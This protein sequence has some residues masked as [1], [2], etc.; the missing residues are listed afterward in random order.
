M[1]NPFPELLVYQL[2]A[3]TLLR[4]AAAAAFLYV[5]YSVYKRRKEIAEITFPL[6]GKGEWIA[7]VSTVFHAAVGFMLGA[8]YYTQIA[9]LLGAIGTL[10]SLF[11]M[12]FYQPLVPLPRAAIALLF[13]ILVSLL[14]TGAGAFAYDIPL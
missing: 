4:L 9:A 12:R 13:V 6:I 8:G 14:L 1:L 11:F 3:P 2:L 7:W 5:A 10:K